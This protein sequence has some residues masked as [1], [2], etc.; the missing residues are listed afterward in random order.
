M[1]VCEKTPFDGNRMDSTSDSVRYQ[2][3][4][5]VLGVSVIKRTTKS[6]PNL[7]KDASLL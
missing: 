3:Q 7:I 1:K 6:S 2:C 4:L 5:S